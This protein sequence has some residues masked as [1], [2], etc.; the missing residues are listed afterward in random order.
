MAK[1]M[2]IG[3]DQLQ[4]TL[5][6]AHVN[7]AKNAWDAGSIRRVDELLEQHR[8]NAGET[9]QRGFEAFPFRLPRIRLRGLLLRRLP[10]WVRCPVSRGGAGGRWRPRLRGRGG[11]GWR[12]RVGNGVGGA[13]HTPVNLS[14]PFGLPL[15]GEC[16]V[17]IVRVHRWLAGRHLAAPVAKD[18]HSRARDSRGG[19]L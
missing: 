6:A 19:L 11:A 15:R 16:P 7:L 18:S 17:Q 12:H 5:Y 14:H 9:D 8:P 2:L 13:T 3:A 4:R 1:E 10:T